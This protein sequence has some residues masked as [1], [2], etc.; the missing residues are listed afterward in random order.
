MYLG[1]RLK[2]LTVLELA[3]EYQRKDGLPILK[4][5]NTKETEALVALNV[6]REI[7]LGRSRCNQ[8]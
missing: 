5:L 3:K 6:L 2:E 8:E 4:G 1:K 7:Q